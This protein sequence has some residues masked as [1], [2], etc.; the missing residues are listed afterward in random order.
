MHTA[1]VQ[2]EL[3]N[4]MA[5]PTDCPIGGPVSG[6]PWPAGADVARDHRRDIAVIVAIVGLERSGLW[7]QNWHTR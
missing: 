1:K 3:T 2:S 7:P 5:W 6:Q 4:G